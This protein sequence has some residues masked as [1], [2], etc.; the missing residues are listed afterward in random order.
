MIK[1][2]DFTKCYGKFKAV[3]NISFE[4]KKGEFVGFV[5]KNGAGKSTTIRTIMNIVSPTQGECQVKNLDVIKDAKKIRE[6]TGYMSSDACFYGGIT[7]RELFKICLKFSPQGEKTAEEL[8]EYFE[9]DMS[10]KIS[11]L[12]L[13]NRKKVAII[14]ALLKDNELLILDEPTNGLDPLMQEKFFELIQEKNKNGTTI[15]LSSHNLMEIEKYCSRVLIIKDGE[16]IDDIDMKNNQIKREQTVS[17]KTKGGTV[18]SYD[19]DGDINELIRQL[20][21]KDLVKLEIKYKSVEDEFIKY[22]KE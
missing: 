7:C 4:I 22:Y 9:L 5:G 8:A 14:Q 10:K 2:N 6:F 1:V 17:Y 13:G 15:F 18:E 3:D 11:E 12:S 20:S 16:I 21:Q 19:Y